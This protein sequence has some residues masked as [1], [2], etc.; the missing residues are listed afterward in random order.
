MS[1]E[2]NE[3]RTKIFESA[4]TSD[5]AKVLV[6][7]AGLVV[8]PLVQYLNKHGYH[9]TIASRTVSKGEAIK[10]TCEHPDAVDVVEFDV[11][12]KNA[13]VKLEELT[14]AADLVISLLPYVFHVR[15]AK[16]AIKHKKNYC[17]AS[18][19]SAAMQELDQSAKDAGI[20]LLNECGVDP[21]LDHMSAKKIIDEVH[22]RGGKVVGFHSLCGG[23]PAPKYN[24]NPW[25]YKLSW[26]PRGVLLASKNS[27]KYLADG[28]EVI[29]DGKDLFGAENV[30]HDSV[31]PV[32][33]LEWYLNRDSVSYRDI[34][35]IP[36]ILTL[37]RGTY[38]YR[39]WSPLLKA[40]GDLSLTSTDTLE[41]EG[42][43]YNEAA[44]KILG[45]DDS[46]SHI[47]SSITVKEKDAIV[48]QLEWLGLFSEEKV[49]AGVNTS[50]DVLCTLTQEK[51]VYL[52]KEKDM[53][54]MRHEFEIEYEPGRRE[55]R[56]STLI[57]YGQQDLPNGNSSMAR[58]VC[59]PLAVAVRHIL[60]GKINLTGV[61]RPVVPELYLPILQEMEE[62][63]VEF[64]EELQDPQ[65]HV[66]AE[67]K[68]GEERVPI[69]PEHCKQMIGAGYDMIVEKSP[70][71]CFSDDEYYKSGC[72][73]VE[74]GSWTKARS[75]AIILG[76]K[77]LPEEPRLLKHRHVYF[78]HCFK[79][80]GGWKDVMSRFTESTGAVWDL[81]FLKDAN[82]R[83][84]AAF[85]RPAG[86]NGCA[87]GILAWCLQ[88]TGKGPL[89][90]LKSWPS[91]DAMI[92]E[93][94]KN[95]EPAVKAYGKLPRVHVLGALGRCGNGA[96]WLAEQCGLETVKW[97]LPETAPGGPF[98]ELL[99]SEILV[100]AIY[101]TEKINPFL[102]TELLDTDDRKISVLVD[103]SCDMS[104]PANPV[105]VYNQE[106]TLR[107]PVLTVNP[108]TDTRAAF[109]VVAIDHLP[110][111]TPKES[112][113][114]F[115]KD[116]LPTLLQ[117][118]DM[119]R[120]PVWVGAGE[121]YLE[122]KE[123]M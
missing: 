85:G 61:Q 104:N 26:S 9:Q 5:S 7:G 65:V 115:S 70:T 98:P 110:S 123:R 18:Y 12:Q 60:E 38:R 29:V 71:R 62:L 107:E 35:D 31:H 51:L 8:P 96:V 68:P 88:Q 15:A 23:L 49:P 14:K 117:V 69:T 106:T 53:I 55:F 57:D 56:T 47:E 89:G 45:V 105:P 91:I 32:G 36:E 79:N 74:A 113:E 41:L 100:N 44:N 78:A 87:V 95:L 17:T 101:L 39:G 122:T 76:L 6:L 109:E 82:G 83:R 19:V 46:K 20:I 11:E 94:K 58:T 37:I 48:S 13:D 34:Y 81:E 66:R 59:L 1:V 118:H 30:R 80:Q 10:A 21:G 90:E 99:E 54:V 4:M 73:L 86:V 22:E 97:D 67:V 24:T 102:T 120:H 16:L 77:E 119:A 121:K 93:V 40:I 25:G 103:V 28:A 2:L 75:S 3:N 111:L 64:I 92:D 42:L 50:L 43:T 33:K 116:L 72:T 52:D 108:K 27:A 112:S 63:G 84:V 114:A